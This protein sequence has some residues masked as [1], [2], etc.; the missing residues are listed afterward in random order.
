MPGIEIRHLQ[1]ALALDSHRHFR[2]AAHALG[3]TQSALSRSIQA[4]E[5]SLHVTLFDRRPKSVTPTVYG[6][7]ILKRAQEIVERTF[8]LSDEIDL[9]RGLSLGELSIGTGAA[10]GRHF[11]AAAVGRLLASHPGLRVTIRTGSLSALLA[12]LRAGAVDGFV[13]DC[14]Q[15]ADEPDV[16]VDPLPQRPITLYCGA[17]HP[18]AKRTKILPSD[19]ADYPLAIGGLPPRLRWLLD[20]RRRPPRPDGVPAAATLLCDDV[21]FARTVVLESLALS[22]CVHG[23]IDAELREGK[24]VELPLD[25]PS[26][27][28]RYGFARLKGRTTPPAYEIFTALAREAERE[29]AERFARM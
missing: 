7:A 20:S 18:L 10:T 2:R 1:H 3:I 15:A 8:A 12:E 16:E 19:L 11:V 23:Q 28:T 5:E 25:S 21:G 17:G 14:E 22:I 13:A 26:L 9:M 27:H 4:L 6:A 24:L 29:A